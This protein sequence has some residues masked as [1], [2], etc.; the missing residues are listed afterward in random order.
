MV[1]VFRAGLVA[2]CVQCVA[3]GLLTIVIFS[4]VRYGWILPENAGIGTDPATDMDPLLPFLRWGYIVIALGVALTNHR[5]VEFTAARI[6]LASGLMRR[7]E[8]DHATRSLLTQ[9]TVASI[10]FAVL[11][12]RPAPD[13]L[14]TIGRHLGGVWLGSVAWSG[15]MSI[16]AASFGANA[17]AASR[18]H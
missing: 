12:L 4:A 9:L 15:M 1:S 2:A 3:T 11:G 7:S 17:H 10:G 14:I 13:L 16:G 5:I 6:R 18:A 8:P